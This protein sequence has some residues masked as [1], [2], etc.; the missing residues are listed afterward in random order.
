VAPPSNAA[1]GAKKRYKAEHFRKLDNGLPMY[2]PT[3]LLGARNTNLVALLL[4]LVTLALSPRGRNLWSMAAFV[5]VTCAWLLVPPLCAALLRITSAPWAAMRITQVLAIA[6]LTVIVAA[7]WS[8]LTRL[9]LRGRT[10]MT[11]QLPAAGIALLVGLTLHAHGEPWTQPALWSHARD[12][13]ALSEWQ[14]LRARQT[15]LCEHIPAGETVMAHPRWDYALPMLCSAFTVA[16][17]PERGWHGM[18]YMAERRADIDE[19]FGENTSGER[20]LA[21]MNKYQTQHVYTTNRLARRIV[22]SLPERSRVLASAKLGA[23]VFVDL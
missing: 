6:W 21:L 4:L 13:Q 17:A 15:L 14:T 16:L 11:L 1:D 23:V 12:Y 9:R 10:R 3:Q 7:P 19:F 8:W 5:A 22:Q 18:P 2:E 20:R